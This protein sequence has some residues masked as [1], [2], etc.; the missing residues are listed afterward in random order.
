MIYFSHASDSFKKLNPHL[1]YSACG[2]E[3]SKPKSTASQTLVSGDKKRKS[4]KSRV[5]VIITLI[6]VGR[7]ELDSDNF[8]AACKPLRDGIAKTLGINDADKRVQ[9]Q[10]GQIY[11]KG[12]RGIL[13]T[14]EKL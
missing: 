12:R 6:G 5:A 13:V 4:G 8:V 3:T 2:L 9:W 1:C 11:S 14:L 10:Y 7:T